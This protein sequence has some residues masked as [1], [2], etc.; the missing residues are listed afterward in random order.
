MKT[1]AAFFQTPI[2]LLV[3]N[4]PDYLREMISLLAKVQP[5][6][7][8]IHGDGPRN[9]HEDD[10]QACAEIQRIAKSISWPCEVHTKFQKHNL[11][12]KVGVSTGLD[13]FFSHEKEGII[14]ED[15]C[16]PDTSFFSYSEELLKKYRHT[17]EIGLIA[18]SNPLGS[19]SKNESSYDFT[20]HPFC[21][22]WASWRRAWQTY[23]VNMSAWPV[24]G[25]QV[26]KK[27]F[28]TES[29]RQYWRKIFQDTYDGKIDTWDYQWTFTCW[30]TNMLC[31]LPQQNAVTN[32]GFDNRATH[33]KLAFAP[34]AHQKTR[35]FSFPLRHPVM[36]ASNKE[37]D[38][39]I[40]EEIFEK[41]L[42][43]KLVT[44]L[45]SFIQRRFSR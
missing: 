38:K 10:L 19:L 27:T 43:G 8:Y 23:D 26:L 18:G 15:D 30:R 31:I 14:L 1:D 6:K 29:A 35:Q 16:R 37:L 36:V 45:R 40:Q 4:R 7:I 17:N 12:C 25:E 3:F 41:S 2:L 28:S 39:R 42:V 5:A 32:I 11:G 24:K 20:I 44:G 33:T 22:G 9:S 13:W 21:W 34:L